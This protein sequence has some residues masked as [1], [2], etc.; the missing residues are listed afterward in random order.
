M[1]LKTGLVFFTVVWV[2]LAGWAQAGPLFQFHH[3]QGTAI[4][5]EKNQ[6]VF[7]RGVSF[8][9][10][11]WVNDR[12][13]VTHHSAEDYSRVRA[14]GMNLV[15]FYLNYQTLELDAAPFEYQADGWQWLDTNIAWARAQG[16]YLILNVHVPQGGFQS[17][18][19]G[20]KLWQDVDLQ[21]RFIAMWRA[22]A[23]RYRDEPVVF[24]Y[25]LLNEPGVTRAKQQ[26]QRLAQRTVDAI[27]L[28]DKKH[29]IIVE[30]VNSINRRWENDADM[31]FVTVDGDNIIYTFHCYDP[32][33]Y[34]HQGIPWD[35]SMKNRDGGV[36]PD[37]SRQHTRA[38][39]ARTIDQYLAWG[40]AHNVP[41]YFGEWGTYKAN[42]EA[43]RGGLNY[44]RDM[45][46]VLEER[47]LTNTFHVYHEESFGIYRGDGPLDPANVNQPVIDMFTTYLKP[48]HNE[49]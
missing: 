18:G 34:S 3:A 12:I 8:G 16:V 40:K 35:A 45:L 39:L 6:P 46:S 44:L 28:V 31:N 41:L 27:R 9:N 15:R 33:F 37:Q 38:F 7:L 36:W 4:A 29:P 20:R 43:D 19:N 13:P 22:I 48:K 21:K 1:S 17:Q 25:D 32:Y 47:K 2:L 10:R 24:G 14:M 26:W 49:S 23:E 42:F 11:V 30:R 5:D